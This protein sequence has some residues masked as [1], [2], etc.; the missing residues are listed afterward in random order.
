[1]SERGREGGGED[2]GQEKERTIEE[3]SRYFSTFSI[4]LYVVS[5][6]F[7][8]FRRISFN[9]PATSTRPIL[10]EQTFEGR[11][12]EEEVFH[13]HCSSFVIRHSS[14]AS[15]ASL[16]T[17]RSHDTVIFFQGLGR[18]TRVTRAP[19]PLYVRFLRFDTRSRIP[20]GRRASSG[21][22]TNSVFRVLRRE[23]SI[24]F[25]LSSF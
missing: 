21:K 14:F 11:E 25:S 24:D 3:S 12:E 13:R 8:D 17:P 6:P 10:E 7:Y 2:R 16:S 18:R 23:G 15:T 1:M 5:T 22:T 9:Q 20:L 4:A 19:S